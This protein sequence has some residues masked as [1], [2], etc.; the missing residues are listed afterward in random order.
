MIPTCLVIRVTNQVML[1]HESCDHHYYLDRID[2]FKLE[3]TGEIYRWFYE[4]P[5]YNWTW[6]DWFNAK[7]LDR[8]LACFVTRNT[9]SAIFPFKDEHFY[10]DRE[11]IAAFLSGCNAYRG[12]IL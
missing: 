6:G 3:K 12:E 9:R 10:F 8:A 2:Q 7:D 1:N 4:K 5:V 11:K